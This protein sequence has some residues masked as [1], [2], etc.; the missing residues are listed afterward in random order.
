MKD[1]FDILICTPVMQAG[2]SLDNCVNQVFCLFNNNVLT[3]EMEH[4]MLYRSRPWYGMDP[5]VMYLGTAIA[6]QMESNY[7]SASL[8]C[9]TVGF[10]DESLMSA[11]ADALCEKNDTYNRHVWLWVV[12]DNWDA[13][14]LPELFDDE[15]SAAMRQYTTMKKEAECGPSVL[16]FC[17]TQRTK[18]WEISMRFPTDFL[19][20]SHFS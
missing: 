15:K 1:E 11:Q 9:S 10:K 16:S 13:S 17:A 20:A 5:P 3:H 12:N 18:K 8:M 14:V 2:Q 6:G 4:H 7:A 19:L